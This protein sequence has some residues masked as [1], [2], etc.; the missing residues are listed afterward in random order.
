MASYVVYLYDGSED[1]GTSSLAVLKLSDPFIGS[2]TWK[3]ES[4]NYWIGTGSG[5]YKVGGVRPI[6]ATIVCYLGDK[7]SRDKFK[8]QLQLQSYPGE[9]T[10][11][12]KGK[13]FYMP[14]TPA[15]EARWLRWYVGDMIVKD[16]R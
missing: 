7:D 10:G 2:N 8:L 6:G 13:G 1:T 12:A 4:T 11:T 3:I 15:A 16:P 9:L 14:N 5:I